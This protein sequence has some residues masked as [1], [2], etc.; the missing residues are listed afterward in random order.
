MSKPP[1]PPFGRSFG[2]K[3]AAGKKPGKPDGK[4]N[5][6]GKKGDKMSMPMP[7]K[8]GGKC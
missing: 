2:G 7:F 1:Q 8:K 6:F 4:P 3:K 5:P